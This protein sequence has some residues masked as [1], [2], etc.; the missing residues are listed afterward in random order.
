MGVV[1]A[2]TNLATTRE[3]AVKLM[4]A[5]LAR[6]PDLASRFL[7]EA[8]A[9]TTVRHPSVVD[10]IDLAVAEDGTPFIVME[11]LR[12]K[13]LREWTDANG[14]ASP[15]VAWSI[16]GPVMR[17]IGAAHRQGVIHR[18]LKP[19]NIILHEDGG[20]ALVPKVLDF[21]IARVGTGRRTATGAQVGTPFYMAPEQARGVDVGP[22]S[23]VW[24]MGVVWFELLTGELPFTFSP[25]ASDAAVLA[26]ILS[27]TP[28][29][30]AERGVYEDG[31][32][33]A[34]DRSLSSRDMRY[35]AMDAFHAAIAVALG[36]APAP[37][38][39]VPM[40]KT[41]GGVARTRVMEPDGG[42][43]PM[44]PSS[45]VPII[46]VGIVGAMVASMLLGIWI[47]RTFSTTPP[48]PAAALVPDEDAGTAL[49][50]VADAEVPTADGTRTPAVP[51]VV[52]SPTT[53]DEE[54]DDPAWRSFGPGTVDPE[55]VRTAA[56]IA[57]LFCVLH[58][59]EGE[60]ATI[61]AEVTVGRDGNVVDTELLGDSI[62]S[63]RHQVCVR[64]ALPFMQV[65][66]GAVGGPATVRF[67]TRL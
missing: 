41:R 48:P 18:D 63:R 24:A 66:P 31:L 39:P 64:T 54:N 2:A 33:G 60:V 45:M 3:V 62:S 15:E 40:P 57:T 59:P 21:G 20:G 46:A 1:Y 52:E 32:A 17:A 16:L 30:L 7:D 65:V 19:D 12:G 53:A 27:V 43:I 61:E 47:H 50:T 13:T 38:S 44:R 23:D 36:E 29:R 28:A 42:G 55:A 35:P 26:H 14:P 34:L 11:R 37:T 9:A 67:R 25:T 56:Q 10:I 58:V 6:I 49:A 22:W 8:R 4:H 51:T 5:D